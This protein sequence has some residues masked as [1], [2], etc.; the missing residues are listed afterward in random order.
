MGLVGRW[1][2]EVAPWEEISVVD[3]IMETMTVRVAKAE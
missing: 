2:V 3:G 1:K